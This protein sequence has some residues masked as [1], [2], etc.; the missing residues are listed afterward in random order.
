MSDHPN[1][2]TVVMKWMHLVVVLVSQLLLL[3]VTYG[4]LRFQVDDISRRIDLIEKK[5]DANFIP[6]AEYDARHADLIEQIRELRIQ[7]RELERK[8][9]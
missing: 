2:G 7:V 8:F 3:G 4:A 1:G 6:R 9:K 5:Q